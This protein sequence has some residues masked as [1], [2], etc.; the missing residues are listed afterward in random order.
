VN[1]KA[2]RILRKYKGKKAGVFVDDGNMFHAQKR[3][4][5]FIDWRKFKKFL[6]KNFSIE[7]IRYYRGIYGLKERIDRRTR[8]KHNRYSDILEG[9]GF[10]LIKRPLKKIYTRRKKNKFKYKC[11]FDAEIGFDIA[12][13]FK[14][15]NSIIIVSGDSDF[16]CL[17][18]KLRE[19]RRSFLMICFERNAPWEIRKIHHLFL[20][21][22]KESVVLTKR[23]PGFEPG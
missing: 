14:K 6:Y 5:W 17:A 15:V 10:D 18:R 20:E 22:I 2:E 19:E 4:G 21:D 8:E 11:D 9:I 16:V 23:K 12:N 1:K 3:A 7:F 13:N